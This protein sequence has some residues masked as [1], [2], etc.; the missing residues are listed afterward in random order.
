LAFCIPR[1]ISRKLLE[2]AKS[3][4]IDMVKLYNMTS[5]GRRCIARRGW[6]GRGR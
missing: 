4:D 1:Y 2:A 5:E 3:G 6:G